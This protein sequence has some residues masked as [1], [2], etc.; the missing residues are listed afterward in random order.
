MCFYEAHHAYLNNISP[1]PPGAIM[2]ARN[3]SFRRREICKKENIHRVSL[4]KGRQNYND[5]HR[6]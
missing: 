2:W 3:S 5:S 1:I 4:E 6:Q